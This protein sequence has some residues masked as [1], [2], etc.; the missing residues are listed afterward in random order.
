MTEDELKEIEMQLNAH[1][2]SLSDLVSISRKLLEEIKRLRKTENDLLRVIVKANEETA[3]G[4]LVAIC[5]KFSRNGE[6]ETFLTSKE[7]QHVDY[8]P[9]C[10]PAECIHP[11]NYKETKMSEKTFETKDLVL[12]GME[13]PD[14]CPIKIRI[15]EDYVYLYVGQRDWEWNIK[16]GEFIGQG[17]FLSD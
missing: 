14:P 15:T 6:S 17:T 7:D 4:N 16:T 11:D 1:E 13:L 9:T 2:G 5:R 8:C 10:A 12:P 3:K